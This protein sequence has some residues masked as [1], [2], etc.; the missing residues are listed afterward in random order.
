MFAILS[1]LG[2]GSVKR[3]KQTW[4]KLPAK[5]AKMFEVRIVLYIVFAR[6]STKCYLARNSYRN[7]VCPFIC[8]S[9]C[10]SHSDTHPLVPRWEKLRLFTYDS[11]SSLVYCGKIL[12]SLVRGFFSNE[13]DKEWYLLKVVI[14]PLITS[15]TWERLQIY[16]NCIFASYINY[17]LFII[18]SEMEI[19]LFI[20]ISAITSSISTA[21]WNAAIEDYRFFLGN[22][23]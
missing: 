19:Y 12:C 10:L 13:G 1:G 5:Y 9:R 2:H 20:H 18:I 15:L 7:S 22:P 16:T 11:M 23:S 21:V 17:L 8:L 6:D 4:D 3:L 14:S